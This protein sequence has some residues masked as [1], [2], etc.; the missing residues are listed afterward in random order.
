MKEI[1]EGGF[2]DPVVY[3]EDP[4]IYNY[5]EWKGMKVPFDLRPELWDEK[6]VMGVTSPYRD[7][8][9]AM[10]SEKAKLSYLTSSHFDYYIV[11][12]DTAHW[13]KVNLDLKVVSATDTLVLLENAG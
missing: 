10:Q 13:Y 3:A 9:D 6:G 4:V 11:S 12:K 8:V 2:Y 1:D 7:Y 5:L